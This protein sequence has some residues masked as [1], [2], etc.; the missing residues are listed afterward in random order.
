[1]TAEKKKV[2]IGGDP[3]TCS[4][5]LKAAG[6]S[7]LKIVTQGVETVPP[8]LYVHIKKKKNWNFLNLFF[9]LCA[10]VFYLH[11]CQRERLGHLDLELTV[12]RCNVVAG[13]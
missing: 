13:N 12:V 5:K 7:Q 2:C 6:S 11:V 4:P 10:L 8:F 9:I 1:V 3:T